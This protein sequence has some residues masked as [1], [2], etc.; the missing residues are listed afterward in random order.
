[1]EAHFANGTKVI[2]YRNVAPQIGIVFEVKD[3]NSGA[4]SHYKATP[5]DL[6]AY[7]EWTER[8]ATEEA[9]KPPPVAIDG[10][11]AVSG[12]LPGLTGM[13]DVWIYRPNFSGNEVVIGRSAF[14]NSPNSGLISGRHLRIFRTENGYFI[15]DLG[16]TN[17]TAV[18]RNGE[19]VFAWRNPG[20]PG[21][22]TF[23]L[24]PGDQIVLGGRSVTF[25][26]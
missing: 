13:K 22:P 26:P 12:N 6:K 23:A 19:Q 24:H 18:V 4:I 21:A 17:G 10:D 25:Q 15:Q 1:M 8:K 16:S 9:N 14:P 3:P 2:D 5:T 11:Q 20:T 7:Q